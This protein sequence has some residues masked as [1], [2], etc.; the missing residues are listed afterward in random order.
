MNDDEKKREDS[1]RIYCIYYKN[2]E[3][4]YDCGECKGR[5]EEI[6]KEIARI[7]ETKDIF[8]SDNVVSL[9]KN[10]EQISEAIQTNFSIQTNLENK[11]RKNKRKILNSKSDV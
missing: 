9:C 2:K 1:C 11:K 6:L 3:E 10:F 7:G 5:A 4:K 8:T